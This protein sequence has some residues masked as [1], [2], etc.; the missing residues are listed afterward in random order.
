MNIIIL[1]ILIAITAILPVFFLKKYVSQNDKNKNKRY[2][3]IALI[4]YLTLI[5]LDIIILKKGA[6]TKIFFI[7]LVTQMIIIFLGGILIYSENVTN[8]K[9]I[10]V[11]CSIIALYF[12]SR[13]KKML[14]NI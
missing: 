14:K 4:S 9:I 7:S 6:I 5:Y 8:N 10:G 3:L 1:Y 2:I 11:I 13:E 12:F